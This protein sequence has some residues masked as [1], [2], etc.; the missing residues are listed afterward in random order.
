VR[1]DVSE[2]KHLAMEALRF[3]KTTVTLTPK[4]ST[5]AVRCVPFLKINYQLKR[6]AI[7]R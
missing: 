6:N 7:Y 3:S 5:T 2:E 4:A 1:I